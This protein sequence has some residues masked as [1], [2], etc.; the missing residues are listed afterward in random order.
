MPAYRVEHYPDCLCC[1]VSSLPGE[2]CCPGGLPETLYLTV[3]GGTPLDGPY[4][5]SWN[6]DSWTGTVGAC[7][8]V[9]RCHDSGDFSV[10]YPEGVYYGTPSCDP[11]SVTILLPLGM[12]SCGSTPVP[13]F[14][15]F[16]E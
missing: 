16:T 2:A 9:L 3:S 4:S 12:T 15:T 10:L 6:G 11:F 1:P 13:H 8:L 14:L 7:A 5:V